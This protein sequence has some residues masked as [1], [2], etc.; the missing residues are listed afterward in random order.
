MKIINVLAWFNGLVCM[1]GAAM[2]IMPLAI[3]IPEYGEP[4]VRVQ[5]GGACVFVLSL[6]LFLPLGLI[7]AYLDR[8]R[9]TQ[10]D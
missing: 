6:V 1:M 8:P 10:P 3:V 4:L 9:N 5:A 7:A 2:G